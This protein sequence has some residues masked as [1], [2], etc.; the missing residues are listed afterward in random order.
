VVKIQNSLVKCRSFYIKFLLENLTQNTKAVKKY[1]KLFLL[2]F[3][4]Q[5]I[6]IAQPNQF[7]PIE[8]ASW[9]CKIIGNGIPYTEHR[10]LCGDT[11]INGNEYAKM[12]VLEVD[13]DGNEKDRFYEGGTR[14]EFD[15]VYWIEDNEEQEEL[16]YNFGLEDGDDFTYVPLS[17]TVPVTISVTST[18][19]INT[20]DGIT[21]R[22][23][24]FNSG[25]VWIEGIGSNRGVVH[26]GIGFFSSFQP[27]AQCFKFEEELVWS[28]TSTSPFPTCEF[29]F[30]DACNTITSN[31]SLNQELNFDFHCY[32]NPITEN[33]TIQIQ[34]LDRME[35]PYLSIYN[36]QGQLVEKIIG[37]NEEKFIFSRK[38]LNAGVYVFEL[39]DGKTTFAV[40]KKSVII[41]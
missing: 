15:R 21:R 3:L 39:T 36:A 16:L 13:D 12:Y 28:N 32:P 19:L 41:R 33:A 8:K 29:T 9:E 30:I 7:F 34:G 6:S 31:E 27:E 26:R 4:I 18:D 24:T 5:N 11:V 1:L 2:I 35:K 22:V 37:L 17:T 25:E 20:L 23:I 38:N 14:I 10:A 40:R